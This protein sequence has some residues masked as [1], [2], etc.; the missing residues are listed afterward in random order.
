M[1]GN[2][3]VTR[4]KEAEL[5]ARIS[6][7]DSV[8]KGKLIRANLRLVVAI[9]HDFKGRGLS[10]LDLIAEGN[11]GL[12][13]AVEKYDPSKG[14]AFSIYAGYWI[15]RAIRKALAGSGG[16]KNVAK[17]TE[18]VH[19]AMQLKEAWKKLPDPKPRMG[20]CMAEEIVGR[21]NAAGILRKKRNGEYVEWK[22]G[23][24]RTYLATTGDEVS[25][26]QLFRAGEDSTF[27]DVIP[28]KNGPGIL[29][30]AH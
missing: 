9:V 6:V 24:I 1:P 4:D 14:A 17:P 12:I 19:F 2:E 16:G 5:A 7:G 22:A 3:L 15:R 20:E 23:S 27:Q 18:S 8:A 13:Q 11:V 29:S 25:L 10:L 21:L 30:K 28:D 26:F